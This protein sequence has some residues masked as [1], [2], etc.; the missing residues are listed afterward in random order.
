[1]DV[2]ATLLKGDLA[3]DIYIE[4]PEGFSTPRRENNIYRLVKSLYGL[5]QEPE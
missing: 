1:M 4:Q 3:K 2:K 5:K